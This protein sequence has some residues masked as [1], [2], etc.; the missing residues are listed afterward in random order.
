MSNPQDDLIA[1]VMTRKLRGDDLTPKQRAE[2]AEHA[3]LNDE[4]YLR[5]RLS[6][7]DHGAYVLWKPTAAVLRVASEALERG[8]HDVFTDDPHIKIRRAEQFTDVGDG[9]PL[10]VIGPG[11]DYNREVRP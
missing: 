4:T 8:T 5:L 7:L 3:A 11:G 10:A 9:V 6:A 2:R 1:D